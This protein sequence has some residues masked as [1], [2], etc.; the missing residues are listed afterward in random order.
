MW[1]VAEFTGRK[2]SLCTNLQKMH[3]GGVQNILVIM[4]LHNNAHNGSEMD[5]GDVPPI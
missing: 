5:F 3:S 2:L 4:M 1:L